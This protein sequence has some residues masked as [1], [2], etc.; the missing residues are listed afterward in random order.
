MPIREKFE[1]DNTPNYKMLPPSRVYIPGTDEYERALRSG[2]IFS[3]IVSSKETTS[4]RLST[5]RSR[6]EPQPPIRA[7]DNTVRVISPDN[8]GNKIVFIHEESMPK[9]AV[10]SLSSF[11]EDGGSEENAGLAEVSKSNE[12][13]VFYSTNNLSHSSVD[14]KPHESG[15]KRRAPGGHERNSTNNHDDQHD[16]VM[17]RDEYHCSPPAPKKL[18]PSF[19]QTRFS[20]IIGHAAVKLR[21]DE[22][23]LPLTL[24]PDVT[25]LV[26]SGI[27]AQPAS[28]LLYGPPG[29]GK[30]RF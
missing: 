15:H 30:V 14:L 17:D 10:S 7:N 1:K 22:M 16:E 5:M 18:Q 23:L 13:A 29:C 21:I 6:E 24:P 8:Q 19:E 9:V 3:S 20:D 28:I 26:L 25:D 27:R 11:L 4:G 2:E 12:T